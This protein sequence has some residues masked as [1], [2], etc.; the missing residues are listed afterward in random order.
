MHG[1][2]QERFQYF[3]VTTGVE[4]A[5]NASARARHRLGGMLGISIP[6]SSL[7]LQPV[8]YQDESD[9]RATLI[10][11]GKAYYQVGGRNV[12]DKQLTDARKW[13]FGTNAKLIIP[14]PQGG[15]WH[16][17]YWGVDAEYHFLPKYKTMPGEYYPEEHQPRKM[18]YGIFFGVYLHK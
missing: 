16:R 6:L 15:P 5:V 18:L 17:A 7:L 4:I 2:V 12:E 11:S 13:V 3:G 1:S 8:G 9:E 14:M 10:L